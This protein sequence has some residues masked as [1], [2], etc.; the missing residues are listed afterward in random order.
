MNKKI[1]YLDHNSGTDYL[2]TTQRRKFGQ[3]KAVE[4]EAFL[5]SFI[6]ILIYCV[7]KQA[8]YSL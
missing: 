6:C 8:N 2:E 7:P 5:C 3:K 1:D 4:I